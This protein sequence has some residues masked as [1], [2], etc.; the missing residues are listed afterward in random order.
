[1]VFGYNALGRFGA[2]QGASSAVV[3]GLDYRSFTPPF[4]G[5]AGLGRMFNEQVAGQISWLIPATV[6]AIA[7]LLWLKQQRALTI[8]LAGWFATFFLM[9]SLVAGMHQFYVSS[10]AIPMV[11]L[12]TMAMAASFKAQKQWLLLLIVAPTVIWS[13][14]MAQLYPGYFTALP[15][16]Q[17]LLFAAVVA[18]VLFANDNL[19]KYWYR[20]LT[21]GVAAAA[22]ALTP[23]AWSVDAIN[24]PSAI[25]PVAG[26]NTGGFGGPGGPAGGGRPGMQLPNFGAQDNSQL[27]NYLQ[28]NRAN[29]EYLVATF[30]AQSAASITT[31]TGDKVL[32]IGGF[33]GQDPAPTLAEFKSLVAKGKLRFVLGGNGSGMG[34]GRGPGSVGND[35][36][37]SS[38]GASIQ[39]WV[40]SNCPLD[41][42]APGNQS[43]YVCSA[44]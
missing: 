39:E 22:I 3:T 44:N 35:R 32:P 11:L 9:L 4:G 38:I 1:M 6:V 27:I 17:A 30:G 40:A 16:L 31:A 36:D 20:T 28:S 10:L 33:D 24:H 18:M 34:P 25:N 41:Q 2:T 8:F 15:Y 5:S 12:V 13:N 21:S 26:P 14:G 37:D 43:V 7:I 23:L 29:A 19:K 42:N